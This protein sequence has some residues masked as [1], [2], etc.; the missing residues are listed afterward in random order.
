MGAL[1]LHRSSDCPQT[2]LLTPS[3]SKNG[4]E[5]NLIRD[6]PFPE[7]SIC[8]SKVVVNETPP[9]S[10]TGA[11]MEIFAH[12]QNLLLHVLQIPQ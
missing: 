3:G 1:V 11:P 9:V 8:L 2:W 7:P 12:F 5:I 10:P 4:A 6:T